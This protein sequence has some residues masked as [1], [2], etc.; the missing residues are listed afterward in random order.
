MKRNK[1][2]WRP[3]QLVVVFIELNK[4][5]NK[6][7]AILSNNSKN[8]GEQQ[9]LPFESIEALMKH[10]GNSK[11]YWIHIQGTGVLT[12]ITDRVSG[13]KDDL[14]VNG[15]KDDF[16]FTSY[17]DGEH[18]AVSFVRKKSFEK[19]IERLKTLKAHL[20]GKTS[21]PI[22]IFALLDENESYSGEFNVSKQGTS[23]KTCE[24]NDEKSHS[25]LF[26]GERVVDQ[27]ILAAGILEGFLEQSEKLEHGLSNDEEKKNTD[28]YVQ[29]RKFNTLGLMGVF[30]ILAL[31]V[32]N[33]FYINYLNDG[34]AQLETD[35]A[36]SNDNLALLDR[37]DQEKA[38]KEQLIENSG[39]R[40]N[41]YIS[42]YLDK[43]GVSVPGSV[44][45]KTL[46]IFPLEEK[47]KE[48]RRV[49]VNP[50][51]IEI[52]GTTGSNVVLDDWI[53]KLNRNEWVQSVEVLNYTKIDEQKAQ[54]KLVMLLTK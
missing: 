52:E 20:I 9:L 42:Y 18:S 50:K 41:K 24:R 29:H 31:V 2:I 17:S 14:I 12:R 30:F 10:Y 49:Q 19:E 38:R 47:L 53:E 51:R 6:L 33:Y 1:N 46:Y 8:I 28:E 4:E 35:L 22:P 16:S 26:R 34:V 32:G 21:G 40:G 37:L 23:I 36:L 5:G 11:A 15:D 44:Y 3:K 54:F 48:K 13:Y 7:S 27:Q 43:I 39:F 25:R 45:L